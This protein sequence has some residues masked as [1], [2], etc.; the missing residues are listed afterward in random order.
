MDLIRKKSGGNARG[1]SSKVGKTIS[2]MC[3]NK[4]GDIKGATVNTAYALFFLE[5]N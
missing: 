3:I 4:V 2:Q 5:K 1:R